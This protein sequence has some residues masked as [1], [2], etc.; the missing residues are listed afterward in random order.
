MFAISMWLYG[1]LGVII[2]SAIADSDASASYIPSY[3]S[4]VVSKN[5]SEVYFLSARSNSSNDLIFQ[6]LNITASFNASHAPLTV[7]SHDLSFASGGDSPSFVYTTTANGTLTVYTGDCRNSSADLWTYVPPKDSQDSTDEGTWNHFPVNRSN[8]SAVLIKGPPAHSSMISYPPGDNSSSPLDYYVFG[9]MCSTEQSRSIFWSQPPVYSA[10]LTQLSLDD[11]KDKFEAKNV[12]QGAVPFPGAGFTMT[13]LFPLHSESQNLTRRDTVY[14]QDF[15]LIGGHTSQ[16]WS[17][18]PLFMNMSTIG[19]LSLPE[20]TWTFLDA[21]TDKDGLHDFNVSVIQP[22]TGHSA[23]RSPDGTK[24]VLVG[25]WLMNT[26]IAAQPQIAILDVG[27]DYGGDGPWTW[28][29]S[30]NM[31]GMFKDGDGIYGHAATVLP[32]GSMII[33]GGYSIKGHNKTGNEQHSKRSE[34]SSQVLV[35]D[36]DS[37]SWVSSYDAPNI[38]T[39]PDAPQKEEGKKA[40]PLSSPGQKAGLAI[41]MIIAALLIA[42]GLIY[43]LRRRRRRRRDAVRTAVANDETTPEMEQSR[44]FEPP[45]AFSDYRERVHLTPSPTDSATGWPADHPIY[46]QSSSFE[47]GEVSSGY[48]RPVAVAGLGP[49]DTGTPR[50]LGLPSSLVLGTTESMESQYDVHDSS[51]NDN[52]S[53]GSQLAP[54][55]NQRESDTSQVAEPLLSKGKEGETEPF[56]QVAKGKERA[57]RDVTGYQLVPAGDTNSS[58]NKKPR[59]ISKEDRRVTDSSTTIQTAFVLCFTHHRASREIICGAIHCHNRNVRL[60]HVTIHH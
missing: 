24:I 11:K 26:T 42:L 35:F 3:L 32:G 16:S 5:Q 15:A 30:K 50:G 38:P 14:G 29:A 43:C 40:G 6:S 2:G 25:G 23:V 8:D 17:A 37:E 19:L 41:G 49:A 18:E 51:Q 59:K 27:Q 45:S 21:Q 47:S 46:S 60:L 57:Q 1:L 9:G 36:F 10:N 20:K 55:G 54:I 34:T 33:A 7:I 31:S 39:N 48:N 56:I 22:R 53:G 12:R 44:S 13:G 52:S 4:S 28:R 58:D